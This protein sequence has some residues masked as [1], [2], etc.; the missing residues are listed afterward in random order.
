MAFGSGGEAVHF[1][2]ILDLTME[3]LGALAVEITLAGGF[4]FIGSGW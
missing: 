3:K 1:I 2:V 4:G